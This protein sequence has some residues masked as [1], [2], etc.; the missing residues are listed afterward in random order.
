[1]GELQCDLRLADASEP[2]D[3]GFRESAGVEERHLEIFE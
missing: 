3:S 1:V 2:N